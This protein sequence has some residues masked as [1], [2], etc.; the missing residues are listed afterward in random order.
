MPV[1]VEVSRI[2]HEE[3]KTA[4]K[5]QDGRAEFADKLLGRR[6]A[7]RDDE[8]GPLEAGDQDQGSNHREL[9][10]L[11]AML[12]SVAE[13]K[14]RDPIRQGPERRAKANRR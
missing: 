8:G 11:R 7:E 9:L 5:R 2:S 6:G 1:P 10:P 14:G 12:V 13:T 3:L 4:G